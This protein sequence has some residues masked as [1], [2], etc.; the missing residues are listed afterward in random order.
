MPVSNAISFYNGQAIDTKQVPVLEIGTFRSSVIDAAASGMR[1][2]ALFAAPLGSSRLRLFAVLAD[3][4][5]GTLG[6][7]S[8][9]VGE[10]YPSITAD[11]TQAHW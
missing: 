5:A 4:G 2:A 3:D 7:L 8:A 9:D 6:A 1:I 10:R 11:C